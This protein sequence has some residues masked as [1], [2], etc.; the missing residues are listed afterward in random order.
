MDQPHRYCY[1][2]RREGNPLDRAT[3]Y[4]ARGEYARQA[5]LQG[6]RA[7]RN[8]FP[9]ISL[10]RGAIQCVPRRDKALFVE[11][12]APSSRCWHPRR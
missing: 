1:L 4:V 3:T 5:R 11:F 9:D 8:A 12:D 6:V 10:K 2:A 7:P